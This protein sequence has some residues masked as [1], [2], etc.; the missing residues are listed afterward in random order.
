M[1]KDGGGLLL[2][3]VRVVARLVELL[4]PPRCVCCVDVCVYWRVLLLLVILLRGYATNQ[5]GRCVAA[6][7]VILV[8]IRL[9]LAVL[10]SA[11]YRLLLL[12]LDGGDFRVQVLDLLLSCRHRLRRG[13]PL[14][15]QELG[16]GVAIARARK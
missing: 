2:S 11:D 12:L 1:E 3:A 13:L 14:E 10:G 6:C 5:L 9:L 4:L 15:Q 16:W 7:L 8:S